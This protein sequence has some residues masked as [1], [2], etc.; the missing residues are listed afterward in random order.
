[1]EDFVHALSQLRED[2]LRLLLLGVLTLADVPEHRDDRSANGTGPYLEAVLAEVRLMPEDVR[3]R[4]LSG[5]WDMDDARREVVQRHL[6][7]NRICPN[8]ALDFLAHRID[9]ATI[10]G[11]VE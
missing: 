10:A 2:S 3:E 1:M 8:V 7:A 4:F 6:R 5:E 11:Y 9:L